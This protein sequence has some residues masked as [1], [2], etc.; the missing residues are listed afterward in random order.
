MKNKYVRFEKMNSKT[1]RWYQL[2]ISSGSCDDDY[3]VSPHIILRGFDYVFQLQLP[4]LKYFL[5][6]YKSE[7]YS[8]YFEREYGF[9]IFEDHFSIL[10]GPQ[11]HDSTTTKRYGCT[12]PWMDWELIRI[13]IL[14]PDYTVYYSNMKDLEYDE[15]EEVEKNVP[16]KLVFT[17]IDADGQPNRAI[18]HLEERE[19]QA[20]WK[21]WWKWVRLFKKPIISRYLCGEFDREAGKEQGSYKGGVLSF[22]H[23]ME[24]LTT[25][26]DTMKKMGIKERFTNIERIQ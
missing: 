18:C 14:N 20:G 17:I 3:N 8:M 11:T 23:Y 9:S 4:F 22:H 1:E 16:N 19:W 24:R 12:I 25:P 15:R 2:T 7:Y 13:T 21:P 5:K 10:Y 6:P 26:L